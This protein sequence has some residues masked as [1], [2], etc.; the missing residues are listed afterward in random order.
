MT[1]NCSLCDYQSLFQS[2][3]KKHLQTKKHQRNE[4]K[5]IKNEE[6]SII[7][8]TCS[9]KTNGQIFCQW[10]KREFKRS[11]N[12]QRHL[13]N[14]KLKKKYNALKCSQESLTYD[15]SNT[16]DLNKFICVYCNLK[17]SKQYNLNRHY[18]TCSMFHFEKEKLEIEKQKIQQL[19][20][21]NSKIYK[22]SIMHSNT[23][24]TT[25]YKCNYCFNI[26]KNQKGLNRHQNYCL[27]LIKI[28]EDK[29][30]EIEKLQ[31]INQEKQQSIEIARNSKNII[32]NNNHNKTINFLNSQFSDMIAME[33]F[34]TALE[35][36]YQLTMDE[37]K[38]LLMAYRDCGIDVFARN[39]SYIMKQNCKRQ[40]E[41]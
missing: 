6:K 22:T 38:T 23:S 10:C 36:T 12:L 18:K 5:S 1:F 31:A 17:C 19:Q 25:K 9:T 11:D 8:D 2:N 28:I 26:Y 29:N 35:H 40:L 37:R 32:I 24:T 20:E 34:L 13:S 14:C 33:Q 15:R 30:K 3:F 39:F 16:S 27:N 21:N 4:E 41:A 7:V